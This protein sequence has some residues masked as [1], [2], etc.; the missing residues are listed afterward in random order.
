MGQQPAHH[1]WGL[2]PSY[3]SL[4]LTYSGKP[5]PQSA[6]PTA[7]VLKGISQ[8][9]LL[10][11]QLPSLALCIPLSPLSCLV[12]LVLQTPRSLWADSS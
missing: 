8:P 12:S 1:H 11:D 4:K 10:T 7:S 6:T 5:I 3:R 2:I 9:R